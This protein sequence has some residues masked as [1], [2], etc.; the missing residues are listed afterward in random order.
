VDT[1][2]KPVVRLDGAPRNAVAIIYRVRRAL[3]KAGLADK[4]A[5]FEAEGKEHIDDDDL[6]EVLGLA[7]DYCEVE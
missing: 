7:F 4:A 6:D 5:E 3:Q 1:A 2:T